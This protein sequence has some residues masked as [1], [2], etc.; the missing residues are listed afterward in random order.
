MMFLDMPTPAAKP[1]AARAGI[2]EEQFADNEAYGLDRWL[3]ELAQEPKPLGPY[4]ILY[5][6]P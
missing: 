5:P 2:D 4:G 3:G 6:L 1:M